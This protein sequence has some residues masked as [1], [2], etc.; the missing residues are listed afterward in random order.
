M[1]PNAFERSRY[2]I[3]TIVFESIL[4]RSGSMKDNK[5]SAMETLFRKPIWS[6]LISSNF[7]L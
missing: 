1:Q 3:W 5:A 7:C 6:G 4:L 2:A